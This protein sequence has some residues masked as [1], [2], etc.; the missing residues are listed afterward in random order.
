M[1]KFLI[2]CFL[3][4]SLVGMSQ[5]KKWN[6]SFGVLTPIPVDI[7]SSYRVDMGSTIGKL[8]YSAVKNFDLTLTTGYM[9]FQGYYGT[10]NFDAVPIMVGGMYHVNK[11]FYIGA[12][13]GPSYF[14]SG[15]E[16]DDKVMCM[17]YVGWQFGHVS[18]DVN[19]INWMDFEN[20][21]NTLAL[22][23]SYTL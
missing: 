23:V 21:H 1:K 22:G 13:A 8:R 17:P 10:D 18:V 19:Y 16:V 9:K 3:L 7:E 4:S 20:Y 6:V 12:S 2:A 5:N 15:F 14:N 11:S